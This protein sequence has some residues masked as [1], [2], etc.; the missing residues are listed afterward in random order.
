MGNLITGFLDSFS[1]K[2]PKKI[3]MLGFQAAGKS[4]IAY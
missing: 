1:S 4:T 3:L 2:D